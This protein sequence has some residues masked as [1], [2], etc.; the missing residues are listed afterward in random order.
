MLHNSLCE[1]SLN[2]SSHLH[3]FGNGFKRAYRAVS[4]G[5]QGEIRPALCDRDSTRGPCGTLTYLPD[6]AATLN[7]QLYLRLPRPTNTDGRPRLGSR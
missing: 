6:E 4:A 7:N 1:C 5:D 3:T 2:R